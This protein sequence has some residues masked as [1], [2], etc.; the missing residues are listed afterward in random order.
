MF[1][2]KISILN[3]KFFSKRHYSCRQVE[4]LRQL[5]FFPIFFS[6]KFEKGL[7][8]SFGTKKE[9]FRITKANLWKTY[10][11]AVF[12]FRF[13]SDRI[14]KELDWNNIFDGCRKSFSKK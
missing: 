7:I 4:K 9:L 8:E 3:L 12:H 10:W 13:F 5:I 1:L 6:Q 14:I 2:G 11:I